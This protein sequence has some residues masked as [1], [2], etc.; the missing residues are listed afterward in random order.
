[1]PCLYDE[2]L[3]LQPEA[4]RSLENSRRG[5]HFAHAFLVHSPDIEAR[6]EFP[7]VLA[8][9]AG[10]PASRD[11]RPDTSCEYCRRLENGTYIES[12]TL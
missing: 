4:V 2:Y 9:I 3:A 7:I 11:G 6:R 8:Q 10:C 1:M 5:G 12:V